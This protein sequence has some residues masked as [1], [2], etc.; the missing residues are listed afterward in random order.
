MRLKDDGEGNLYRADAENGTSGKY[1]TW[2]SVGNVFYDEGLILIKA[3]QLF[4]FGKEGFDV[5]FKGIQNIHTMTFNCF[6]RPMTLLSSS[7]PT[8]DPSLKL[9]EELS[10]E[11]DQGFVYIT[12]I[13][14]HDDDMNIIMKA[15][16]AQPIPKKSGDKLL[17][18]I[19]LDF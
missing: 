19:R 16:T 11:P 5:E 3:P 13:N 10:N 17:F 6:A 4:F 14:I 7:N 2:A 15:K 9:N 1:A 12:G 18:K 8:W